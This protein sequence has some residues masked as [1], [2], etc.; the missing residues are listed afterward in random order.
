MSVDE[1]IQELDEIVAGRVRQWLKETHERLSRQLG[2]EISRRL[3]AA[4]ELVP[5]S[6]L[7]GDALE[8]LRAAVASAGSS[9]SLKGLKAAT[10]A[11][12]GAA[13]QSAVLSELLSEGRVF[14]SRLAIF[15]TREDAA[16]GWAG[17]GFGGGDEAVKGLAVDYS[18]E[19]PWRRLAGGRTCVAL[20]AA[21]CESLCSSLGTPL[22][23]EGVLIPLVLRDRVAA[24]LYADRLEEAN[25]L[26]L[27]GLQLL[28]YIAAQ[29]I[30]T[31]PFRERTATTPTLVLDLD[32][33]QG[34][35]GL[36]L[37]GGA[38]APEASPP[39]APPVRVSE[40]P[41]P[42]PPAPVVQQPAAV[43]V[44]AA[45]VVEAPL[46]PAVEPVE[47]VEAEPVEAEA[48]SVEEAV[49][50]SELLSADPVVEEVAS[51]PAA[52]EAE[53]VPAEP[54]EAV[55]QTEVQLETT[56][57]EAVEAPEVELWEEEPPEEAGGA[58]AGAVWEAEE[59]QPI[60]EVEVTVVEE[61]EAPAAAWQTAESVA[62]TPGE[63][64][65]ED[66]GLTT[67]QYTPPKV[68]EPVPEVPV[69]EKKVGDETVLLSK[70]SAF[71]WAAPGAASKEPE[72]AFDGDETHPGTSSGA[73]ADS[74]ES[75]G[76]RA[77]R[78]TEVAPPSDIEGPGW[79]FKSQAPA[80]SE[81]SEMH[82]KAKRL[83]RLLVSEI[84]LYNEELVEE[85][86]RNRNIY[87]SLKEEI[88]RSRQAFEDRV[89][90]RIRN[91]NDYFYQEL[92]RILASGDTQALGI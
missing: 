84:K 42:E 39:V 51:Q 48:V 77:S 62:P 46:P 74:T 76:A 56:A 58:E 29:A 60:E 80:A 90:E 67:L 86:Q 47:V 33:T 13:N 75:A 59:A 11:I 45:P 3:G 28:V 8:P 88:D 37:W 61:E 35:G 4:G 21:D 79:A 54:T 89:D 32:A 12:D 70:P 34:S 53:P 43:E 23:R 82:E 20:S 63:T 44:E 40:P 24:A 1:K 26:D 52:Q 5:G 19:G 69:E 50:V 92:V 41:V 31:L 7:S 68:E 83:A 27:D 17:L 15:L 10:V 87:E 57:P 38:A 14:A 18:G 9:G 36:S 78:A 81:D 64:A 66:A 16:T 6:L 30:E 55:W 91:T 49:E 65:L 25:P 2:D 22:P 85:G 71:P 73:A 72:K